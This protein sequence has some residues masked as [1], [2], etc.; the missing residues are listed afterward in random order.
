MHIHLQDY[1]T[2]C[3]TE[4]VSKAQKS[5][6]LKM[7]CAATEESD[8]SKV[9]QIAVDN[10]QTV[11]PAFGIHPW[12]VG[13]VKDGWINR[14]EEQLQHFPQSII[15]ES[16]LDG[17]KSETELQKKCFMEQIKLAKALNRPLVI[18]AVKAVSMLAEFWQELP[19]YFMLHSFNGRAEHLLPALLCG[20]YISFSASILKNKDAESIVCMV[21]EDKLLLESDGPYQS[22]ILGVEQT[23]QILPLL[24]AQ[25]AAWRQENPETLAAKI[26]QNS[27]EFIYGR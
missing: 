27:E 21:P 25:I 10:P 4:I 17:L 1:K 16:G 6:I 15:G 12:K 13:G 18:H 3:A 8:W 7:V 9:A 11:I 20:G 5:G 23:P 26:Y 14:L 24:L 2:I 19:P 22:G